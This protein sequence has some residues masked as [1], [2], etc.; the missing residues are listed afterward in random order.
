MFKDECV[1]CQILDCPD[2]AGVMMLGWPALVRELEARW[3]HAAGA[4]KALA[5]LI[6]AI[7]SVPPADVSSMWMVTPLDHGLWWVLA[8]GALVP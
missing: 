1:H 4:L 8:A 2:A 5:L 3:P 6:S 7:L